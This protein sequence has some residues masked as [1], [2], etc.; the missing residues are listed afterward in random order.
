MFPA[1]IGEPVGEDVETTSH[2]VAPT[3]PV[4]DDDPA[5]P[6][7]FDA[8]LH[9]DPAL[10]DP[11]MYESI[12]DAGAP[13][14][15]VADDAAHHYDVGSHD[16]APLV[17]SPFTNEPSLHDDVTALRE[18]ARRP[19]PPH[20]PVIYR[21][22][23]P[24]AP[25]FNAVNSGSESGWRIV[26]VGA[27]VA[28]LILIAVAVWVFQRQTRTSSANGA[29]AEVSQPAERVDERQPVVP[30]D[31]GSAPAPGAQA[32]A[33][34]GA[35][36]S[37]GTPPSAATGASPQG[38][39][40]AS[41]AG[42]PPAAASGPEPAPVVDE[43]SAPRRSA[44]ARE[45]AATPPPVDVTR[46]SPRQSRESASRRA[47]AGERSTNSARTRAERPAAGAAAAPAAR[48]SGSDT[49]ATASGRVLVRST[50]AGATV[51]VDG[52]PRGQT[53]A[54]IRDLPFGSHVIVVTS[55]GYSPWQQTITLTPDRPSQSFEVS[56]DG[57]GGT[58]SGVPVTN[59]LQIDSRPSGARVFVDGTAVGVTP[60]VLPT[61]SVGT[62]A[63]R[64][65]MAGYQPWS[66]SV[67]VSS[68][69]RT[70]VSA[71]LEQ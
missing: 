40:S 44:R 70:R 17:G 62:H 50:P 4:W 16:A 36:S 21:P 24:A 22:P 32:A 63:I 59:G 2:P 15:L 34:A 51:L 41:A 43:P 39:P 10:R 29:G 25:A 46:P 52:T 23:T 53:P 58:S 33:P 47:A 55:L 64:I 13:D 37:P 71:S 38:P 8:P 28:A 42:S 69:Q 27:G 65:E 1:E 14:H 66:T 45:N 26:A 57:S 60:V 18:E 9:V 49:A 11:A 35:S 31:A 20:G 30:G 6:T 48:A 12:T 67:A 54:A 7:A 61:V 3:G 68:G 56:L 19:T 5:A